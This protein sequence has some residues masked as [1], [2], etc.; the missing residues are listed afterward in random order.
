MRQYFGRPAGDFVGTHAAGSARF[1]CG[2]GG[3][4]HDCRVRRDVPGLPGPDR[5]RE[6]APAFFLLF[7]LGLANALLLSPDAVPTLLSGEIVLVTIFG[8]LALLTLSSVARAWAA[9]RLAGAGATGLATAV[10]G[11]ARAVYLVIDRGIDA[12]Y[13]RALVGTG[14]LATPKP[15]TVKVCGVPVAKT[16]GRPLLVELSSRRIGAIGW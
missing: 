3:D 12:F 13:E 11:A 4:R 2:A 15:A 5:W 6:P 7:F 1:G 16:P 9:E 10:V 14:K 8:L